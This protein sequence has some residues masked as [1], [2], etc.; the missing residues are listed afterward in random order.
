MP[1]RLAFWAVS[2][3]ALGAL[4]AVAASYFSPDMV[5]DLANQVWSCF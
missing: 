5:V 2:L 1:R 4:A 3:A